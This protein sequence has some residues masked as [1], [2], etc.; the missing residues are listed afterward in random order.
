MAGTVKLF[1][2]TYAANTA[3]DTGTLPVQE[4]EMVTAYFLVVAGPTTAT[5]T[6]TSLV[7]DAGTSWSLITPTLVNASATG[8]V[9]ATVTLGPT[10]GLV[11]TFAAYVGAAA[12]VLPP[13]VRFQF[14]APG[15]AIQIRL[16][17]YGQRNRSR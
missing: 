12:L 2:V 6:T 3:G 5:G 15:V 7:D 17:V 9:A 11:G 16:L 14:A 13:R 4:F 8:T 10:P 1:D